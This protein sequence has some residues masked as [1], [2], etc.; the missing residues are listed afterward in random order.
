MLPSV[1][2]FL[3]VFLLVCLFY[4]EWICIL[5]NAF[6]AWIVMIMWV[7][8]FIFLIWQITLIFKYLTNLA[9]L[10]STLLGHA[11]LSFLCIAEF[12]LLIICWAFFGLRS[13]KIVVCSFL[14]M[15][16]SGLVFVWIRFWIGVIFSSRE[17]EFRASLRQQWNKKFLRGTQFAFL[18]STEL[19]YWPFFPQV[20][21]VLDCP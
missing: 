16:L 18:S 4:H 3:K 1:P 8:F 11:V 15:P 19:Y 14:I 20:Q 5:S 12:N 6:S 9:F 10:G 7:L 17:A 2:G 21:M 13:Q